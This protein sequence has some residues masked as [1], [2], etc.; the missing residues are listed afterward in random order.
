MLWSRLVGFGD[1]EE[2]VGL[3]GLVGT[4]LR[5]ADWRGFAELW[6][7]CGRSLRLLIRLSRGEGFFRRVAF[8]G[9]GDGSSLQSRLPSPVDLIVCQDRQLYS[10]MRRYCSLG[11]ECSFLDSTQDARGWIAESCK[12]LGYFFGWDQ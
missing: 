5:L 7:L 6:V 4:V 11:A 2:V 8:S 12:R 3:G 1:I 9:H 10:T